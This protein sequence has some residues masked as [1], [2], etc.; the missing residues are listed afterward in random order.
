MVTALPEGIAS[1][2]KSTLSA[3]EV[4]M[5]LAAGGVVWIV[6][7]LTLRG[8]MLAGW[9]LV[10][11]L[12]AIACFCIAGQEHLLPNYSF[13]GPHLIHVGHKDSITLTDLIGLALAAVAC[14]LAL[15]LIWRRFFIRDVGEDHIIRSS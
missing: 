12:V 3:R 13:E 1:F 6:S 2:L 8:R 7:G 10:P 11:A 4:V 9:L 14:L 5:V 15:L